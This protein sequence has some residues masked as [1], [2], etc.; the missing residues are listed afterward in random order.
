[1]STA[2]R[3]LVLA[4]TSRCNLACRYCYLAAT[5]Q[6]MDMDEAVLAEALALA[7]HGEPCL[8]Q[9][10][11]GEP[12]LVPEKIEQVLRRA[13]SMRMRPR[14]A[15][16]TNATLL[17]P[18]L[19]RLFQ[20]HH[21]RIGVSLDGPPEIQDRLRGRADATLRGLV[22]LEEMG[23]DFRVT[24]VVTGEN[25]LVLDRLALLLAGFATCRGL[26]LD[27]LV[28]RGRGRTGDPQPATPSGLQEGVT[29]LAGTLARINRCR[30]RPIR[31]R[32]LDLL[33]MAG[34]GRPFCHAA[35]GHSLAVHP[36]GRLFPCGQ[37]MGWQALAMGT[38]W[39]PA[40]A[41]SLLTTVQLTGRQCS[42][43]ALENRC[44]GD[45]PGR[46]RVNDE[47]HLACALYR[48]LAPFTPQHERLPGDETDLTPGIF[49]TTPSA[50]LRR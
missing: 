36:D 18:E 47:P 13:R 8:V 43:C 49:M 40:K 3:F 7:D 16:Q 35:T 38:V 26:G 11:G 37:T 9:I 1:M 22:L 41:K 31:L 24:T 27:L 15:I 23:V 44:P 28:V 29:A 6:G 30:N 39:K 34:K 12:T 10:T 45:C 48:A 32:E 17:T 2:V 19:V 50:M 33:T 25:V 5:R 20:D 21:V 46:L 42:A 14:L 4:L